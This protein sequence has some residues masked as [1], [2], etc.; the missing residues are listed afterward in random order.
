MVTQEENEMMTRVGPGTPGGELLRRYWHPVAA[1][2]ELTEEEPIRQIRILSED[3]VLYRDK[4]GGYGLVGAQCPHRRASLAFGKVDGEGIRCPYH[5]WK[6]AADGRCLEQPAE[7]SA[8]PLKDETRHKAYP[9]RRLGGL[10][11]AY[12]GPLPAPALPHWDVLAWNFG[13]RWI[14]KFSVIDCNWLQAAENAVDSSHV[15]W[16]HGTSTDLGLDHYKEE[17]EFVP[18]EYGVMKRRLLPSKV[19]GGPKEVD[20]HPL[21]FPSTLRHV[22]GANA[23]GAP[24]SARVHNR[25]GAN[26][27]V[28]DMQF[29][30]PID[31][32]HTLSYLVFF[33]ASESERMGPGDDVPMQFF[34]MKTPDG[35]YRL[36][37]VYAQDVMAWESQGAIHD[38]SQE[39]LGVTDVGVVK[40]RRMLLEQIKLVQR[41]GTPIGVVP[42]EQESPLIE[43]EVIRTRHG[44]T[45]P[46]RQKVAS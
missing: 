15:Y 1:A 22:L 21:L 46:E 19:P 35:K 44:L 39:T 37:K 5:G 16:L 40:F 25:G 9:V 26:G 3:L 17:H 36:D 11:F 42:A 7:P 34:P 41:G 12:M 6:F 32:T 4:S 38:R 14:L 8:S 2:V 31:D 29:R 30:V 43:L 28:H 10:L 33:Q 13:K 18:F 23:P 27:F 45:K 24:E 20:Q